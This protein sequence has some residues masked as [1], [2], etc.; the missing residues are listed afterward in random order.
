MAGIPESPVE[1]SSRAVKV[2]HSFTLDRRKRAVI[3]GVTDVS[4]FQEHEVVLT[5]E[6]GEMVITGQNLHIS[7]LLLEEGQLH[8]DGLVDGVMYQTTVKKER[9]GGRFWKRLFA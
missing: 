7:K 6:S 8:L 1:Q 9:K 5:I 4:S 2:P 3:T